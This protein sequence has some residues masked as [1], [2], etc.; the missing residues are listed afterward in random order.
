MF[1]LCVSEAKGRQL[2]PRLTP[3][4]LSKLY[5]NI[6]GMYIGADDGDDHLEVSLD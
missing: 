1:E 5:S 2:R 6:S 4:S 3:M